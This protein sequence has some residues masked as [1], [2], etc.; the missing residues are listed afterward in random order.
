MPIAS[1]SSLSVVT[2]VLGE[3]SHTLSFQKG[4]RPEQQDYGWRVECSG[5][6]KADGAE[7]QAKGFPPFPLGTGEP[8]KVAE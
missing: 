8:L 6:G 3:K 1:L 2:H 5:V 4:H 7:C